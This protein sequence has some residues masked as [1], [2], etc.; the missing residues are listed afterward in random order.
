[1]VKRAIQKNKNPLG[2]LRAFFIDRPAL[3]QDSILRNPRSL[4]ITP[5][6]LG[7]DGN[8]RPVSRHQHFGPVQAV[9][10]SGG[11]SQGGLSRAIGN[12]KDLNRIP[13]CLKNGLRD[14]GRPAPMPAL[15]G[16]APG[17]DNCLNRAIDRHGKREGPTVPKRGRYL[18]GDIRGNKVSLK[19][20]SG[21]AV[22]VVD[23][24]LHIGFSNAV[25][26]FEPFAQQVGGGAKG[27]REGK[28]GAEQMVLALDGSF[29]AGA[30]SLR[31]TGFPS[32]G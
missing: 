16:N 24:N 19:I 28:P 11:M 12:D 8:L 31:V 6:G 29:Q 23:L 15:D 21:K 10:H 1:M 22:G 2:G 17:L 14:N 4:N 5:E 13:T 30:K 18:A 7:N 27:G 3:E 20:D 25:E 26:L 9:V 32:D